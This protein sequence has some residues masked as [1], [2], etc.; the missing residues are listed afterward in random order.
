MGFKWSNHSKDIP[1]D[2]KLFIKL[3][4][5]KEEGVEEEYDGSLRYSYTKGDSLVE[6]AS[7]EEHYVITLSIGELNRFKNQ[8]GH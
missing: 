1:K 8:D 6:L 5:W 2:Y 3:N 4:G 7:I